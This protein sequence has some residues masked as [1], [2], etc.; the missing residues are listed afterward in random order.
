MDVQVVAGCDCAVDPH[1]NE[2]PASWRS[3]ADDFWGLS[4]PKY[5]GEASKISGSDL[6]IQLANEFPGKLVVLITGPHTDLALA[7]R[8]DPTL[9]TKIKKVSIMGGALEVAGNIHD[10][11]AEEKNLVSEWNIWVD[12]L[13]A[14]EVFS[15]GIPLDILPMD[16]VPDVYL[17]RTFSEKVDAVNLPGADL[18][19]EL[20]RSEFTMFN[21]DQILMWDVLA[22]I[23]IDHPDDFEWM[24]SPVEVITS[25]GPD[26]GRTVALEGTSI[27]MRYAR[28]A[29]QQ[30]VLDDLYIVFPPS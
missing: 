27:A 4:L 30:G 11:W 21:S 3:G 6:I 13:A 12:P 24:N 17:N 25:L 2:F 16:A 23:A 18:M 10:D 8:K 19:A 29:N 9:K 26:Q 22:A 28:H 7:L 15:S 20:W 1:P 5:T 14:A